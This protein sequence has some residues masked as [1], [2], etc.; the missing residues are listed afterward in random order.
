MLQTLKRFI[1]IIQIVKPRPVE[2]NTMHCTGY[3]QRK[4][5]TKPAELDQN[6]KLLATALLRI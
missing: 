4:V 6:C 3:T 5:F 2:R 1:D